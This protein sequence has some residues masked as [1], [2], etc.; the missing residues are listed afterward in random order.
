MVVAVAAVVGVVGSC[1]CWH[2]WQP[3]LQL[4]SSLASSLVTLAATAATAV[5]VVVR[6]PP[7]LR[8]KPVADVVVSKIKEKITGAPLHPL[9]SRRVSVENLWLMLLSVK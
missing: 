2:R 5:V 8:R 4:L 6:T 9:S 3:Q 7:C 1:S